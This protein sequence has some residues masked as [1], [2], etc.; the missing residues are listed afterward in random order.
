MRS[1]GRDRTSPCRAGRQRPAFMGRKDPRAAPR[2]ALRRVPG[3]PSAA[4]Q[5]ANPRPYGNR[6]REAPSLLGFMSVKH[7][8]VRLGLEWLYFSGAHVLLRPLV[9]GVGAT[10]MLHH[11]RPPRRDRFQS[12]KQLEVTPEFLSR[13]IRRLQCMDWREIGELARNP[14]VTIGAHTVNH[15]ML[16]K[17]SEGAVR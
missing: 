13:V 10:L 9:G 16:A 15:P 5:I 14:Q 6:Y 17:A 3:L 11:V 2:R 1:P 4:L 12:N 7:S 8:I